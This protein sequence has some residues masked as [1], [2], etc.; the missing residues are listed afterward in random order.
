MP[1]MPDETKILDWL[2]EAKNPAI[3]RGEIVEYYQSISPRNIFLKTLPHGSRILDFGAGDG[4]TAIL[5]DWPFPR[6]SDLRLFALSLDVGEHFDKYEEYW[7][8]DFELDE[9][10]FKVDQF[11]AILCCHCIEHI[12][13]YA[14]LLNW[15]R[16]RLAPGGRIYI[17]WPHQVAKTTTRRSVLLDAG[18]EVSTTNF[19]DD[20][21]HIETWD[22]DLI[23]AQ[24]ISTGLLPETS[25]RIRFPALAEAMRDIGVAER[26]M[27]TL[28]FSI[29][30]HLGWA[31]Y[32]IL[33]G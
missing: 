32:L 11:D 19:F 21:T 18:Y 20:L 3:G 7:I 23:R 2:N 31:Q 30:A 8:G 5:R 6:R 33:Q 1:Q 27:P 9:P 4:T 17:E 22:I 10:R 12:R 13:E 26:D 15:F 28:T 14:R 29:W 16:R 25:G 24:A